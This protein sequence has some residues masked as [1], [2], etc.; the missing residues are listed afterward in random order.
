[1]TLRPI[2]G[3]FTNTTY[4]IFCGLHPITATNDRGRADLV[5]SRLNRLNACLCKKDWENS[6]QDYK[7][8]CYGNDYSRFEADNKKYYR[9][10]WVPTLRPSRFAT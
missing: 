3:E 1:M 2:D 7:T 5:C 4:I 9:I 6:D 10:E 8:V